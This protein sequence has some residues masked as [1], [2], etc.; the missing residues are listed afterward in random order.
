MQKV[1][2]AHHHIWRMAD[3]PWLLQGK[4]R[5]FGDYSSLRRD[6]PIEEFKSDTASCNVVKSVYVQANWE[7]DRCLEEA[8]WVHETGLM[9]GMPNG[10][11]AHAD[12]N[13]PDVEKLLDEYLKIS[14]VRGIR[15]HLQWHK[16]PLLSGYVPVPDMFNQ[17]Q[18]RK[19]LRAL[20]DRGYSFDLQ[21]FPDQMADAAVM[22]GEFPDISFVLL[23]AGM[24]DAR[25][26]ATVATWKAGMK[27]FSEHPNVYV[28]FSGLGTFVHA[29]SSE[30]NRPLVQLSIDLFGASRCMYGSNFPIEK[31]WT[32]YPDYFKNVYDAIGDVSEDDL[33]EIFYGTAEKVYRLA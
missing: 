29:S 26:D 27:A 10:I 6:Y 32:T 31:L 16:N 15:Q 28:K 11:V 25:D 14:S 8:R 3:L 5:I 24:L 12:L 33:H 7:H 2:D 20:G 9:H 1:I 21:V 18:W 30:L 22:V 4:P 19:G 17:E 13:A 23:H